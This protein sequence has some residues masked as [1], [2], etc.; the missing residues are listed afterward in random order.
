MA[1]RVLS[2]RKYSV[3]VSRGGSTNLNQLP[4]LVGVNVL[5]CVGTNEPLSSGVHVPLSASLNIVTSVNELVKYSNH[6]LYISPSG[7]RFS[8]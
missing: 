2:A 8:N 3:T 1:L 5:L 7:K 4:V 6:S